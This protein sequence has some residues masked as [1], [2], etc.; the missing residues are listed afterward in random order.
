MTEIVHYSLETI[1][2]TKFENTYVIAPDIK[3]YLIC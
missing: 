3:K 2:K 1:L